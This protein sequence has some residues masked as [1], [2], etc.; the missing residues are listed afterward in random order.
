MTYQYD[1][2]NY[3]I[4]LEKDELLVE[5]LQRFA[6]ETKLESGWV[7]GLGAVQWAEL[8]FYDLPTQEYHWKKLTQLLEITSLQGNLSRF[9]GKPMFHVHGTFSGPDMQAFG[10][11]V[12]EA[13]VA[14]TCEIFIHTWFKDPLMRR[15]DAAVGLKLLDLS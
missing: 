15:H 13:A 9:D 8:G 6:A 3:I 10:G 12:K 5:S 14:A 4:R 1:G 7:M 11:H 2:Y